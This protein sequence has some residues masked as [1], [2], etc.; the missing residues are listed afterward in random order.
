M[1]SPSPTL[2][3][4]TSAAGF[5]LVLSIVIPIGGILLA[6]VLGDRYVRLVAFAVIP[7]GLAVTVAILIALPQSNGPLV[8]LLGAWP[9]PLGIALRADG[10]SAV[11]LAAAAA[12]ICA[13]A[14][15]AAADFSPTKTETR[16]PFAFWILL[17]A[18]WGALNTIFLGG[19]L[20]TLY[21]ALE[22]L[23]F[24]AVPLVSLEGRAETL[25]AALRYLLFALLG[26]VLYLLG[27]ALLYG[28]HGTLDIVLL[29]RLVGAE[30]AALVAAA[31]MTTGLLAKTALFPLH[32]W[33]PSAHA[34]APSA[35]SAILS[36]L[37]V[38]GSFFIVVRLWFN[39]MPGLPGFAATQLLAAL[40][41]AAIVFGSVVALRQERLKLLIAYSTLA[42]I[43]YLFLMFPLALGASG[44]LESGGALAG[45]LLQAVSHA[46]A[47][48]AMFLAAGSIYA[49]LG[50]DR[51]PRLGGAGRIVPVS[52]LAFALG[53]LALMGLPPGGAY[54]AKELLLQAAAER[55]Q[56]W[57][58]VVLQAGGMFT[59]AYVLL[60]LTYAMAPADKQATPGSTAP[61]MAELA[62]IA[63]ALCSLLLGLVPWDAYLSMPHGY[64]SATLGLAALSK[65]LVPLLGGA[66]VA[67]LIGRW[68]PAPG[69]PSRW[70]ALLAAADPIRR[71]ALASSAV[72]EKGDNLLRQW[73]AA[74]ICL[75]SLAALF[76]ASMW[77]GL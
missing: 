23:T 72:F 44:K 10:L 16:A 2:D 77:A 34:G 68:E 6:F 67:I 53:G 9:P 47:K 27:T 3:A 36:G 57:W 35:A 32:L 74:C 30:P 51:I 11:M 66:V 14:V 19:D 71:T 21:V 31:L 1:L 4:T 64:A 15:F 7:I 41:G 40:G 46:T 20:F 60:V 43:G 13:V 18:I 58:A 52:V 26:S 12:V 8:Y 24:A 75:L 65:A 50:Q 48:A 49:A 5:L 55:G 70:K 39:V 63:L 69:H 17:L 61:R 29:S 38:K 28:L 76:A 42:Q 59:A 56:W 62:A 25:R 22:L 45:G 73:P 33:L 54:L 37:V